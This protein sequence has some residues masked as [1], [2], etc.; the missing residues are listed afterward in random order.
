MPND[1][2]DATAAYLKAYALTQDIELAITMW[3]ENTTSPA[4]TL[5][6]EA[7]TTFKRAAQPAIAFL[8][9]EAHAHSAGMP[10]DADAVQ[11][12]VAALELLAASTTALVAR[13]GKSLHLVH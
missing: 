5:L 13:A 12:M 9:A 1:A 2:F 11:E 6:D 3:R 8:H 4:K 10:V 7:S